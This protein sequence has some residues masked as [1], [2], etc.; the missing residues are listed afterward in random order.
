LRLEQSAT[1]VPVTFR[2]NGEHLSRREACE[3][4]PDCLAVGFSPPDIDRSVS[5]ANGTK[6]RPTF[7]LRLRE[8]DWWS[9][10]EG[11]EE[12]NIGI[13]EVAACQDQ[14]ALVRCGASVDVLQDN[15]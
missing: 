9:R 3:C 10:H 4:I 6:D 5:G 2:K 1:L 15:P 14:R 11:T 13:G 12:R 8:E 7:H